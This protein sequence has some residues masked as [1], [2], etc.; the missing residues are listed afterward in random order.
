MYKHKEPRQS[1]ILSR[2]IQMQTSYKFSPY[3]MVSRLFDG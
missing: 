1:E 3:V 2:Q